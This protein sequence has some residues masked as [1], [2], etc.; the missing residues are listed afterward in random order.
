MQTSL[1]CPLHLGLPKW[2]KIS[3]ELITK[4]SRFPWHESQKVNRQIQHVV[5]RANGFFCIRLGI[6][7]DLDRM[8]VD[9]VFPVVGES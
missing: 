3:D 4:V 1:S 5:N 7:K 9:K 6:L 8:D 2:R